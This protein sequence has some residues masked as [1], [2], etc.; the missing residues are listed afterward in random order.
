MSAILSRVVTT[1]GGPH[2]SAAHRSVEPFCRRHSVNDL[3]GHSAGGQTNEV[4]TTSAQIDAGEGAFI[5][6]A[7]SIQT[8]PVHSEEAQ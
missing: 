5:A 8:I 7:S 1:N 4:A 2:E 6:S 3:N